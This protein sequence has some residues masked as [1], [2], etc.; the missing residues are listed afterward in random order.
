VSP[1]L[2]FL[3]DGLSIAKNFEAPAARR[4]QLDFRVG[5]AFIDL[6]RQ[7]GGP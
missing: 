5:K 4:N 7:T 2:R 3:E 1:D 6:G